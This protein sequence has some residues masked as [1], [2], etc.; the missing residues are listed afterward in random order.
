M[1]RNKTLSLILHN[2]LV[3]VIDLLLIVGGVVLNGVV[4]GWFTIPFGGYA[5][6]VVLLQCLIIWFISCAIMCGVLNRLLIRE[7]W[8]PNAIYTIESFV[9]LYL[10]FNRDS[11]W[12]LYFIIA[13]LLCGAISSGASLIT[14][15]IQCKVQKRRAAKQAVL[16]EE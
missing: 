9:A 15:A 12:I 10:L 2:L 11:E 4:V 14:W 13:A 5:G 7:T 8:I 16:L 1:I 6:I 3:A